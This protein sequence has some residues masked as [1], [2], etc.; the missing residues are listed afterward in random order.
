V[1]IYLP[2]SR[3]SA[4]LVSLIILILVTIVTTVFLE[5]IWGS[6]QTVQG[7]EASNAAYYQAVGII[8]EQLIATNVTKKTPWNIAPVSKPIPQ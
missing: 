5:R 4:L 2:S 3:G 8:E 7:I 1:N 6:S